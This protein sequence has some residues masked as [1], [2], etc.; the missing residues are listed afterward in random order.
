MA[1]ITEE[2]CQFEEEK[3]KIQESLKGLTTGL[4][5]EREV[6]QVDL[7]KLMKIV[8]ESEAAVCNIIVAFLS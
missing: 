4:Q 3:T 6:L 2:K 1:K 7:N 8:H 5:N